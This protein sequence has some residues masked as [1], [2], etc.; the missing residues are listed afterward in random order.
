MVKDWKDGQW[1]VLVRRMDCIQSSLNPSDNPNYVAENVQILINDISKTDGI[2]D[3]TNMKEQLI[4]KLTEAMSSVDSVEVLLQTLKDSE[5]NA[6]IDTAN[7]ENKKSQSFIQNM[8]NR[9]TGNS[10][11]SVELLKA[12]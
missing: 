5:L 9:V 12:K 7:N 4:F 1:G 11:S 2:A 3:F 6:M 10:E 8:T